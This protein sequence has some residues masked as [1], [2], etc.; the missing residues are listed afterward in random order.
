[1]NVTNP[2]CC[3]TVGS[4]P[5]SCSMVGYWY[6]WRQMLSTSQKVNLIF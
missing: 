5:A 3:T 4:I 1:M 6:L 2:K